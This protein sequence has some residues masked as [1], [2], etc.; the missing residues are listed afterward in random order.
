VLQFRFSR[1]YACPL[2]QKPA[3]F[4]AKLFFLIQAVPKA[5]TKSVGF[6]DCS[7]KPCRLKPLE[8]TEEMSQS[9]STEH[10]PAPDRQEA[11]I[12]NAKQ[13]CGECNFQFPRKF[14]FHG[15]ISRRKLVDL[16]GR[17]SLRLGGLSNRHLATRPLRWQQRRHLDL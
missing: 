14:P 17:R 8:L 2:F 12:W 16:E 11:W 13:I 7:R 10:I 15:L 9:F 4:A 1:K 3:I 5:A 6:I